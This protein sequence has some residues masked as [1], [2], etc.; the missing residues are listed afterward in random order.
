[1]TK[2][3]F[4]GGVAVGGGAPVTIQ[5]MCNTRTDDTAATVAQIKKLEA[6]GCQLI[7]VAIPDE[8][9]ALAVD[10]VQPRSAFE[11]MGTSGVITFCLD[12][13]DFDDS[14]LNRCHVVPGLWLAHGAMSTF[15][16]ALAWLRHKI[17]PE[18]S[19]FAELEE[20]AAESLPG[21]NGVLFLPYLSGE[22][23]PIW[24]SNASG[25]WVGLRLDTTKA[26]MVRAVFEGGAYGLR[27]I[28]SRG[29]RHWGWKPD[30]LLSVGGG[31]RSRIWYQIK[32]DILD[33]CYLPAD[34]PDATAMGAAI[35]GG[36]ASGA[37]R[38]IDD[39]QL[40]KVETPRETVRPG[41][42][43]HRKVYDEMSRIYDD[44]Y[45]ALKTGMARIAGVGF[46]PD[47]MRF[48]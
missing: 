35:L 37:Y 11:S 34:L 31:T 41:C 2:Q 24:D 20:L 18:T 10:F 33:V 28:L 42:P 39:P 13:P 8:A 26:D 47:P 15:G 30:T 22:R 48:E 3:I 27:Q 36:I 19:S 40:P 16:G 12:T 7:R 32:A 45:P 17:W 9:A 43:K 29:E 38:G 5:S 46:S 25:C 4:V 44:L 14:F 6:A 1:M 21:A 23:S